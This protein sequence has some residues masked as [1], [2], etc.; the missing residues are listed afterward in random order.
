MIYNGIIF[1]LIFY[2][3]YNTI[4][5]PIYAQYV[6]IVRLLLS[7]VCD[8]YLQIADTVRIAPGPSPVKNPRK[9]KVKQHTNYPR[10]E[11]VTT[12]I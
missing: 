11:N 4:F 12:A 9:L 10:S 5:T 6:S 2:T 7:L 1:L 3:Y 8:I